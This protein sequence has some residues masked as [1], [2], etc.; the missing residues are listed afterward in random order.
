MSRN[1][2]LEWIASFRR[3]LRILNYGLSWCIP[4]S[5]DENSPTQPIIH[6][7]TCKSNRLQIHRRIFINSISHPSFEIHSWEVASFIFSS[8]HLVEISVGKYALNWIYVLMKLRW[9]SLI[10]LKNKTRAFTT[11][12][13]QLAIR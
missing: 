10:N 12:I 8:V 1:T 7:N 9:P 4:W 5:L 2:Q 11:D 6:K 3:K 13:F